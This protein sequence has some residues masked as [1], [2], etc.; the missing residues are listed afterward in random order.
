MSVQIQMR[1]G[2]EAPQAH[3]VIPEGSERL[4]YLA[5]RSN[6]QRWNQREEKLDA[7]ISDL[8]KWAIPYLS[9]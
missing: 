2:S 5:A 9:A 4:N 8:K 6:L 3:M 1:K 7:M